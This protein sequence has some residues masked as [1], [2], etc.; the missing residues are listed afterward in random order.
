VVDVG[1]TALEGD[2]PTDEVA[3]AAVAPGS[4]AVPATI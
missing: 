3:A 4:R 1:A 2:D